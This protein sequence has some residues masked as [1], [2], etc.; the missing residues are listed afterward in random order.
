MRILSGGNLGINTITP[1]QLLDVN[2]NA[3]IQ[4][5]LYVTDAIEVQEDLVLDNGTNI[6]RTKTND[7]SLYISN[8]LYIAISSS[9]Y[10]PL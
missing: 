5:F 8:H 7:S 2:G 4:G 10:R 6:I 1:S 9:K 3:I